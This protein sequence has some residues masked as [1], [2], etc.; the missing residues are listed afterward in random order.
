MGT[1]KREGKVKRPAIPNDDDERQERQERRNE[2]KQQQQQPGRRSDE[3]ERAPEP[4]GK[5]A[6]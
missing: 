5:S 2:G 6:R 4:R 1:E 3:R